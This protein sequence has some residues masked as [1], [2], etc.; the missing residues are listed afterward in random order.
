MNCL[1]HEKSYG[2]ESAPKGETSCLVRHTWLC[3]NLVSN[4]LGFGFCDTQLRNSLE[5]QRTLIDTVHSN[6]RK[7]LA[8]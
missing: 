1:G 4:W 6:S 2:R 7:R 8:R 3:A 5:Q